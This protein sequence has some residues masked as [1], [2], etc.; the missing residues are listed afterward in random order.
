MSSK[1]SIEVFSAG[2]PACE[3]T[4][5]LV[6]RTACPSCEVSVLDMN[7][8]PV[9]E[10]A[11]SLGVG[12]VPAVVIDGQLAGC[13]TGGGPDETTLRAAGLGQPLA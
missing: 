10:R 3:E 5:E 6:R 11:R 7:E 1:R 9:A 4:L 13:C 12:A 8:P 2:C